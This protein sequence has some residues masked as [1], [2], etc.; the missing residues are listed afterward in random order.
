[1]RFLLNGQQL[2]PY[3]ELSLP[4]A[5]EAPSASGTVVQYMTRPAGWLFE[6]LDSELKF[7]GV[8]KTEDEVPSPTE[9]YYVANGNSVAE[10]PIAELRTMFW[11]RFKAVR[12]EKLDGGFEAAGMRFDSDEK[13]RSMIMGGALSAQIALLGNVPWSKDWTLEDNTVVTITPQ[14]M[15]GIA[16]Y[17]DAH[18]QGIYDRG[19][20]LRQLI[21]AAENLADLLTLTWDITPT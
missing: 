13:S 21:E 19:V 16:Q 10:R 18:I 20:E 9:S 15:V 7:H 2:D 11:E 8:T 4:Y 17:M 5:T 12:Q 6:A 3:S 1:M 14:Q